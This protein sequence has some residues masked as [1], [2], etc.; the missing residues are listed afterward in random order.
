MET[1]VTRILMG[2]LIS[3]PEYLAC[4]VGFV[5]AV[6][7]WRRCPLASGLVVVGICLLVFSL[8]A[9]QFTYSIIFQIGSNREWSRETIDVA[10]RLV[11]FSHAV[12]NGISLSSLIAAAFVRRPS[13]SPS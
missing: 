7:L 4:L 8:V 13:L 9:G 1:S 12:I 10:F 5:V 3:A 11:N 2:L 6:F